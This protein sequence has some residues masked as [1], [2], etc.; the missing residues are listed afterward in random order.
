MSIFQ[1]FGQSDQ[2]PEDFRKWLQTQPSLPIEITVIIPSTQGMSEPI[3]TREMERRIAYV[4]DR[5]T[6]I[7][8]GHT[9]VKGFGGYM[10]KGQYVGEDVATVTV[11]TDAGV[12][13]DEYKRFITQIKRWKRMW[14]QQSIGLI[15]EGDM[16]F[17]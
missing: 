6:K 9:T 17:I 7:F 11:F 12:L 16:Y 5:L 4:E 13:Q 3:S 10:E 15:I 14:Q 1:Y 8:G 2:L